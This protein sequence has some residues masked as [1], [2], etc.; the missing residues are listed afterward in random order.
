MRLAIIDIG[1]NTFNMLIAE[2]VKGKFHVVLEDKSAVKLGEGGMLEKKI[3]PEPFKRGI[4]AIL[5]FTHLAKLHHCNQ[6]LAF[7]TAAVRSSSN[8][9]EFV[10]TVFEQTGV[11]IQV[12]DGHK[13]ATYIAN[14]ARKAV[15]WN[16][17]GLIMD[18]GGGSTEFIIA[19]AENNHFV[20]STPLGVSRLKEMFVLPDPCRESDLT[21]LRKF[22]LEELKPLIAEIENH[23]V[24]SLIG[25]SGSFDSIADILSIKKE[26][27]PF[28]F[29]NQSGGMFVFEDVYLLLNHITLS[30]A[31]QRATMPGLPVFRQ[32]FMV[33]AAV[34]IRE[35]MELFGIK[36]VYLSAYSLKEGAFYETI[37]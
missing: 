4:E 3:Q 25:C 34:L 13:E 36:N 17:N 11:E 30:T 21:G 27:R 5:S 7:A 29:K 28:D 37:K 10:R 18:I 12:I 6:I 1:T 2:Q 8:G 33:Y 19:D 9:T 31:Y 23:Q 16:G 20:I 35:V 15:S 24:E 26:G 22:I 14:G 32:Q